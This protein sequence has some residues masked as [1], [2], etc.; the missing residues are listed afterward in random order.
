VGEDQLVMF[1]AGRI[2]LVA[3]VLEAGVRTIAAL[4]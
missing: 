2:C 3:D 1:I 4:R